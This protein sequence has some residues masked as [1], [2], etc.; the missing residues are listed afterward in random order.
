M[1]PYYGLWK[2]WLASWQWY[3]DDMAIWA[4]DKELGLWWLGFAVILVFFYFF[5]WPITFPITFYIM[6]V[7]GLNSLIVYEIILWQL[8]VSIWLV[9]NGYYGYYR[10]IK[11]NVFKINCIIPI[12]KVSYYFSISP[13]TGYTYH[14]KPLLPTGI[15]TCIELFTYSYICFQFFI[16]GKSLS[17][18]LNPCSISN[19]FKPCFA[20]AKQFSGLSSIQK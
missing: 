10:N 4:G 3:N 14:T 16:N 12:I 6:L 9:K 17:C 11:C 20:P 19:G 13:I 8:D 15:F 7:L 18:M 1:R 5:Y 2:W